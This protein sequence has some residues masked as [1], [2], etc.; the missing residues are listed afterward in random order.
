MVERLR[1]PSSIY[2]LGS[3]YIAMI[4]IM[5]STFQFTVDSVWSWEDSSPLD[6]ENWNS[7]PG[8]ENC[9]TLFRENG[10]WQTQSCDNDYE[11][12]GFICKSSKSN[13]EQLCN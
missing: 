8:D 6:F 3:R 7:N 11:T 2:Y 5:K 9:A 4:P 10:K 13:Y 12:G 1:I